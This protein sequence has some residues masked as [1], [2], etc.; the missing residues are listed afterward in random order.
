MDLEFLTKGPEYCRPC[1][2]RSPSSRRHEVSP[3]LP[4]DLSNV[5]LRLL[6]D[7]N[8][9][10]KEW[11]VRQYDHEVRGDTVIKPL[12]GKMNL[13]GPSD[14]TVLKPLPDS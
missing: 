11:V 10:S 9:A 7:P 3:S 5:L 12:S 8:I 14:A 4:S 6:S 2:V 13:R 1:L